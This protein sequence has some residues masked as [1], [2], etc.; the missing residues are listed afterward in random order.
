MLATNMIFMYVCQNEF[1]YH[2]MENQ[3]W[4]VIYS[5]KMIPLSQIIEQLPYC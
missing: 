4:Y 5:D 2:K 1:A 3:L